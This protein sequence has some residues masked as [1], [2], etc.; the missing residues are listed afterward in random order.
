ML[1]FLAAALL[2]ASALTSATPAAY[3]MSAEK[4]A[5]LMQ[6]L[7]E[8][9]QDVMGAGPK[10]LAYDGYQDVSGTSLKHPC[11]P[12]F[13]PIGEQRDPQTHRTFVRCGSD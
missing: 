11:K 9:A 4:H 3:A 10:E 7:G 8:R 1:K 13:H 6:L 5:E 12:G 2:A